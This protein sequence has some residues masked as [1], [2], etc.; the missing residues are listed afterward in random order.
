MIRILV[1]IIVASLGFSR[2]DEVING[3]TFKEG[4]CPNLTD[5]LGLRNDTFSALDIQGLWKQ[6]YGLSQIQEGIECMTMRIDPVNLFNQQYY[7]KQ[8]AGKPINSQHL[9]FG[10]DIFMQFK[11]PNSSTTFGSLTRDDV[12]VLKSANELKL[13][14]KEVKTLKEDEKELLSDRQYLQLS[15]ELDRM[16]SWMKD[17]NANHYLDNEQIL[18]TD[19]ENYIMF[20]GCTSFD[21]EVNKDG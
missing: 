11:H 16:K 12:K 1:L 10:T 13:L 19:F 7:L 21:Q 3:Q 5:T 8:T 17:F 6:V 14:K 9:L 20:Y 4:K 18:D 15:D 2:S